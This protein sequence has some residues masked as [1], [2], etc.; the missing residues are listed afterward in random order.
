MIQDSSFQYLHRFILRVH[1]YKDQANNLVIDI[2]Q[3]KAVQTRF[4]S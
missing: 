4:N 3:N 2:R 1:L